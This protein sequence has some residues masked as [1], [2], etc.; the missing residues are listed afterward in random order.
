M[1][2][3]EHYSRLKRIKEEQVI[4]PIKLE[5]TASS[6]SKKFEETITGVFGVPGIGKSKLAECLGLALQKKYSLRASGVYFLQCEPINHPW[7]IRKSRLNN[8]PTFRQFIDNACADPRFVSTVK[9]WVID[10]ID[11]IIPKGISTICNDFGIS[12]LKDATVRVGTDGWFAKAWQELRDELLYQIL[13][14]DALGPGVLILSHERYRPATVGRMRVERASMDVSN[15]IYNAIGDACSMVI[16]MRHRNE[17]NKSFAK[18]PRCLS[19]LASEDEDVK[20]NLN[21][22]LPQYPKGLIPFTTEEQ[23]VERLLDCFNTRPM[24]KIKKKKK[25]VKRRSR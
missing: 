12:D 25:K 8:W 3:K 4:Q 11:G 14:L 16:R 15:S 18:H 23:A 7:C 17:E 20:D 10:T 22:V 19:I 6:C 13:R 1:P 21:I 9:M 2:K 5:M 24:R